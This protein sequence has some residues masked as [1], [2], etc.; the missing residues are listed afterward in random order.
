M[1]TA[2]STEEATGRIDDTQGSRGQRHF[3]YTFSLKAF[4]MNLLF[5]NKNLIILQMEQM[6]KM[7]YTGLKLPEYLRICAVQDI[8]TTRSGTDIHII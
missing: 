8:F 1:N 2:S 7:W 4:S 6:K 5:F 3:L